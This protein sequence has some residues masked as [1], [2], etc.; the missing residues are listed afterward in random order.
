ML[1][2]KMTTTH[3]PQFQTAQRLYSARAEKYDDSHHPSFAQYYVDYLDPK[4]GAHILDLACGTGLVTLSAAQRVGPHGLVIGVDVT[5]GML[6][7]AQ[8]SLEEVKSKGIEMG[9]VQFFNH[10]ITDL[11][12]LDAIHGKT[13]DAITCCSALVLLD[14]PFE[15]VL[16]WTKYLKPGGK[17]ITDAQHPKNITSGIALERVSVRLGIQSPTQRIWLQ[18]IDDLKELVEAAGLEVEDVHLQEQLGWGRR[19]QAVDDGE[20]MWE[21][22]C[23][24]EFG[25]TLREGIQLETA[26]AMFLEEW[27]SLATR[28]GAIEEVDGVFLV[29]AHKPEASARH[30]PMMK[31]SCACGAVTWSAA[32]PPIAMCHCFCTQ[33]RKTSGSTFQSM[34]EFPIWAVS[35]KPRLVELKSVNLTDKARRTFCGNCGSCISYRSFALM[36]YI[37]MAMGTL[38]IDSL[39]GITMEK[40]LS[41]AKKNWCCMKQ[42]VGWWKMPDDGWARWDEGTDGGQ[43]KKN[44]LESEG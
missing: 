22:Y 27:K 39:S 24:A 28:H 23:M 16:N 2:S 7:V 12:S 11:D 36:Q 9:N 40:L 41:G 33:C 29:K 17:L 6:N 8:K 13:F 32:I 21:K 14:N 4:P 1:N 18:S 26:K 42:Q 30:P 38:D 35:F 25:K 19:Y 20:A 15:V 43:Y 31:G 44:N 37:E 3:E 34:M 10:D 5:D